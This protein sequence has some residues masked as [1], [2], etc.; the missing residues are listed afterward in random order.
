MAATQTSD[1]LSVFDSYMAALNE[2]DAAAATALFADDATLTITPQPP[3]IALAGKEQIE[4]VM[5]ASVAG[6]LDIEVLGEF[7]VDGDTVRRRERHTS[8]ALLPPGVALEGIVTAV[9]RD[10]KIQA[11]SIAIPADELA[12]LQQASAG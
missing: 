9:V 10:G 5:N 2:R 1:T 6:K 11:I 3:G 8:G 7:E 12:K 4:P